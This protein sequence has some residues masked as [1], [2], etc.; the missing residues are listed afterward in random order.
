MALS[1]LTKSKEK[2]PF[3]PWCISLDGM[4][5]GVLPPEK[6]DYACLESPLDIGVLLYIV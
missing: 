4:S 3:L 6:V 2:W 5:Q 1:E